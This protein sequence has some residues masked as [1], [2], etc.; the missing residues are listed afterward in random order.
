MI[1][2]IQSIWLLL[3]SICTVLTVKF[4]FYTGNK[5]DAVT[6]AKT[7]VQLNAQSDMMLTVLVGFIL[8]ACLIAIFLFK[9]RKRQMLVSGVTAL[10]AIINIIIYISE[11]RS[12]V[13][14]QYSITSTF[15]FLVPLFLLLAAR[16][17]WKDE[18]LVKSADR[19]R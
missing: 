12:F 16:A 10:V 19:L 11:T 14:G 5:L 4:S 7:F 2:R 9:D 1:Q 3:A 15:T 18:Q 6:K 8:A 13:E 17:I